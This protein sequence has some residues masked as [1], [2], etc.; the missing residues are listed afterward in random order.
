MATRALMHRD[1]SDNDDAHLQPFEKLF[2]EWGLDIYPFQHLQGR[3]VR[4]GGL[5]ETRCFR[6]RWQE[7]WKKITV[8]RGGS[9]I[10]I[11]EAL[12]PTASADHAPQLAEGVEHEIGQH[13][14]PEMSE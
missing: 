13:Q 3:A 10:V 12:K 1:P 9:Q 7:M 4:R 11:V 6:L 5:H 2:L 8:G 14:A